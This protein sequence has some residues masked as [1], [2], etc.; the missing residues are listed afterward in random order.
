LHFAAAAQKSMKFLIYSFGFFLY[1]L[2]IR[3]FKRT[4]VR[5][6]AIIS[7][8]AGQFAVEDGPQGQI[9]P[10]GDARPGYPIPE[11]CRRYLGLH[12]SEFVRVPP[13]RLLGIVGRGQESITMYFAGEVT[14]DAALVKRFG[15]S[16][17]F[18]DRAL[19]R[20]F[21]PPDIEKNYFSDRLAQS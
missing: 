16:L 9:L 15:A 8:P 5:W 18:V 17:S 4:P 14:S 19:L 1:K 11:L 21:V 3:P 7:N 12:P 2:F 6:S 13:L 20:S 10:S